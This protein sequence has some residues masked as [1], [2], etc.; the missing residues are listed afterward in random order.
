MEP[1]PGTTPPTSNSLIQLTLRYFLITVALAGIVFL[2]ACGGSSQSARDFEVVQ[3]DG[4]TF[5]LSQETAD[6]AVVLNF[7]YP[8]CP[9]CREE[10]PAFEAAWQELKDGPVRFLGLYV[11]QGFD[12]E[13]DARDFVNELGLTFSFATDRLAR[14]AEA[15][16]LEYFPKTFFIDMEGNVVATRISTLEPEEIIRQVRALTGDV[17]S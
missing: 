3:F 14:I 17:A 4:A 6:H 8:S 1:V 2:M 12:S 9:P 15:Y 7:W 13:Q 11:P 10:M 5:R 16:E